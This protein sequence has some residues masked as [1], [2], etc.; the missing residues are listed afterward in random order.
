M[1]HP[2]E[3]SAALFGG[4]LGLGRQVREGRARAQRTGLVGLGGGEGQESIGF[5]DRLTAVGEERTLS[6]SKALKSRAQ[7]PTEPT[8][9]ASRRA[10]WCPG[11]RSALT[12]QGF[13]P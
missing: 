7:C 13:E 11:E 10:E 2:T 4:L 1:V 12:L 8:S 5:V 6:W 9:L 3:V